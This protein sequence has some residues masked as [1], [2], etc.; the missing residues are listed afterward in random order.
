MGSGAHHTCATYQSL[1]KAVKFCRRAGEERLFLGGGAAGGDVFEGIPQRGI[2]AAALVGRVIVRGEDRQL[3]LNDPF[4]APV[5][6]FLPEWPMR[7]DRRCATRELDTA[8]LDH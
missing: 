2:A 4:G 3:V 6:P 1:S 7:A 8:E 5:E